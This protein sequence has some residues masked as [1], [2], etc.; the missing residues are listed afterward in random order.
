MKILASTKAC[1]RPPDTPAF[2]GRRRPLALVFGFVSLFSDPQIPDHAGRDHGQGESSKSLS[3]LRGEWNRGGAL[4]CVWQ[5][6]PAP[7]QMCACLIWS[8]RKR[9]TPRVPRP[10]RSSFVGS[11]LTIQ[12]LQTVCPCPSQTPWL[13]LPPSN[14]NFLSL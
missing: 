4:S 9:K 12:S 14:P 2:Q 7:S 8:L 13:S 10:G 6:C 1:P 5:T 3:S 11:N